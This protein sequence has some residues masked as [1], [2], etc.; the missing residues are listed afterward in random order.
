MI[1]YIILTLYK[2]FQGIYLLTRVYIEKLRVYSLW[3]KLEI[4]KDFNEFMMHQRKLK[5]REFFRKIDY[6]ETGTYIYHIF[7]LIL[8]IIL[9]VHFIDLCKNHDDFDYCLH[10][11]DSDGNPSCNSII[12][13]AMIVDWI[14]IAKVSTMSLYIMILSNFS[15]AFICLSNVKKF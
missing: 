4:S 7:Y 2:H 14:N 6:L 3:Y 11:R 1:F 9:L 10:E 12:T 8:S 13:T 5:R 15:S